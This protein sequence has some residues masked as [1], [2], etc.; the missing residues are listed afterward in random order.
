MALRLEGR[1]CGRIGG[2]PSSLQRGLSGMLAKWTSGQA[3]LGCVPP[4][5]ECGAGGTPSPLMVLGVEGL[6]QLRSAG[7]RLP[8]DYLGGWG[9]SSGDFS[10]FS[11]H[12]SE[13]SWL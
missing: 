12:I 2:V 13:H 4:S 8:S 3:G 5:S 1:K 6:F 7:D 10:L 9:G 11:S